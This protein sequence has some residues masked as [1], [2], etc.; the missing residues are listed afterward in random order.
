MDKQSVVYRAIVAG[1]RSA[2]H[3]HGPISAAWIES[4][5]KRIAAAVETAM[6]REACKRGDG[7]RLRALKPLSGPG[8]LHDVS[9]GEV[10][11]EQR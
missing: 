2:I 10:D 4:A 3:T 1:L 7:D 11:D 8:A 9:L 6:G 5:A